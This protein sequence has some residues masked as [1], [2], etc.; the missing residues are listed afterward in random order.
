MPSSW[1]K[2][3][4]KNKEVHIENIPTSR[5]PPGPPDS[6]TITIGFLPYLPSFGMWAIDPDSQHGQIVVEVY[7]HRTPV[8]NPTFRLRADRDPYWYPFFR[9][10][11]AALWGSCDP[12]N[13]TGRMRYVW[14]DAQTAVSAL[15]SAPPR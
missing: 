4:I 5:L 12:S 11:L 8:R 13:G 14:P 9:S 2:D 1:W 15:A 10:Q 7:H 6:G 3:Q